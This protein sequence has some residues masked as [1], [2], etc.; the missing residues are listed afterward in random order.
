MVKN[1]IV[2]ENARIGFRNFSGRETQFNPAGKRNF[3]VFLDPDLATALDND[4]WNVKWLTPKDENDDPQPY[5]QV[6]VNY[7]NLPP[8]VIMIT[9]RGKTIL[10]EESLSL[11]DW[12]D[13][14]EVDLIINPYNW[15]IQEGTK[16][17]K[18]GIKA[19]VKSLYVTIAEDEFES[20]YFG[21]S[22]K[23]DGN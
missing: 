15:V 23:L 21:E 1:T 2:I 16:N 12:A 14:I 11:L 17:E 13:I 5:L 6:S 19:Y 10:D 9:S 8:K 7:A 20:K 18:R 3:C 4:G 22:D